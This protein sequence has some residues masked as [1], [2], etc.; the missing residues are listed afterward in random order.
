MRRSVGNGYEMVLT[1]NDM[2]EMALKGNRGLCN[3]LPAPH[4]GLT[5][6]TLCKPQDS[7]GGG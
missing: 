6:G 2:H 4:H 7:I 5:D 1:G 3:G